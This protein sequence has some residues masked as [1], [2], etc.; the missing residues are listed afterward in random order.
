MRP[1][2][3]WL[4]RG[5]SAKLPLVDNVPC[6]A[7]IVLFCGVRSDAPGQW[8]QKGQNA[9]CFPGTFSPPCLFLRAGA[10]LSADYIRDVS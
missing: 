7:V 2:L 3:C 10:D 8:G 9:E 1:F 6:F 5:A 4:A